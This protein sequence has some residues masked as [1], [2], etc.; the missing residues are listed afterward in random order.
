[1]FAD[2]AL[3]RV[4]VEA[5]GHHGARGQATNVAYVVMPDHFHW[6]LA[7]GKGMTLPRLMA[8]VKGYSSRMIMRRAK[9][10]LAAGPLWQEGYHDHALRREEDVREVARYVV[11]NP[12]RAGLTRVLADYPLWGCQWPEEFATMSL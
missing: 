10:C 6:L 1:M 4:V 3:G 2:Y 5:M 9:G 7:L 8:S 11:A 12:L